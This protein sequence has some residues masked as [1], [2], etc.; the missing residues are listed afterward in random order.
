MFNILLSLGKRRKRLDG[1]GKKLKYIDLDNKLLQWFRERRTGNANNKPIRKER[2]S[3]KQLQRTGKQIS[4]EMKHEPPSSKWYGRFLKR[5]RLSLQ[6]PKR[7]QKIPLDEAHKLIHGFHTYIRRC[8]RWGPKRGSMGAFTPKDVCNMDESPLSLFGDQS[9]LTVNDINTCNEI[10]GCISNKR[11]C[12]VILTVFGDNSNR[13]GPV[14]LFKGKGQVS[15]REKEQYS[16]DVKVF[17]TPKAVNNKPTMDKYIHYWN[18][19]VNDN[20]PK[21]FITDSAKTHLN[22]E[23]LRLLRKES[24][25]V[26]VVPKGCTMYIQALDVFVFS[27]F[28]HHYY[29]CSEEF[30]E[31]NGPRSTIKLTAS[32]SRILCTRLTSSAWQRTLQSIDMEKGFKDLGYV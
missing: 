32:Q 9:K 5:H 20:H 30:I 7:Q 17:F 4:I 23:T 2:V 13:V 16:K 31:K 3:F 18:K 24:V 11:F 6:K 19:K 12:T 22:D 21:L 29:E 14:L 15:D 25:V 8:S 28:K 27:V 1:G 26:A 10:E